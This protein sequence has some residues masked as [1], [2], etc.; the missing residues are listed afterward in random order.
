MPDKNGKSGYSKLVTKAATDHILG[1]HELVQGCTVL[2]NASGLST[3]STRENRAT[4]LQGINERL[5]IATL[6]IIAAY[7]RT[8]VTQ[9]AELVRCTVLVVNCRSLAA[10][11]FLTLF[12]ESSCV[13]HE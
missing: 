9:R 10:G 3:S 1:Q 7:C 8:D 13:P 12:Y 6:A 2:V 5:K 11:T 4:I